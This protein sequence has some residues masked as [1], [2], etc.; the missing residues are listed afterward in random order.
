MRRPSLAW[1]EPTDAF[2]KC[3]NGVGVADKSIS[4]PVDGGE[5]L[6][7]VPCTVAAMRRRTQGTGPA[8]DNGDA[9]AGLDVDMCAATLV[10]AMFTLVYIGRR[11]CLS[12][13]QS[14]RVTPVGRLPLPFFFSIHGATEL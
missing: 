7:A 9:M 8:A 12:T 13:S 6:A 14:V 11:V 2:Q 3:S 1:P 4:T 10:C 5:A